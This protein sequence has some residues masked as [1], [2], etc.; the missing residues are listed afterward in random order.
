MVRVSPSMAMFYKGL[1]QYTDPGPRH[2]FKNEDIAADKRPVLRAVILDFSA[3]ATIDTTGVQSLVDTRRQLNRYSDREVE[4]HFANILSPWVRRALIAGGFGTGKPI[5][6]T[7]EIAPVVPALARGIRERHGQ[8]HGE[9]G[10]EGEGIIN[11]TMRY[12]LDDS[13][14]DKRFQHPEEY[15]LEDSLE[16][17]DEKKVESWEPLVPSE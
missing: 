9:S 2:G 3:V 14:K 7:L 12:L 8:H 5:K 4:F 11:R 1:I 15:D 17:L 16:E 13:F 6:H 10:E